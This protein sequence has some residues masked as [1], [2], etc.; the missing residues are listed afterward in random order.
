MKK[1]F[2]LAILLFSLMPCF[3]EK[4]TL[5]VGSDA[6]ITDTV[7]TV[8]TL[9]DAS[10]E[11][12]AIPLQFCVKVDYYFFSLM[13][14]T[15]LIY[16]QPERY[17]PELEVLFSLQ[18]EIYFVN[19]KN[20]SKFGIAGFVEVGDSIKFFRDQ[21]FL[22][23]IMFGPYFTNTMSVTDRIQVKND[24]GA[25]IYARG[26]GLTILPLLRSGIL[27]KIGD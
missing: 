5:Y 14:G 22:P 26:T 8:I 11:A 3:A 20:K 2:C 10:P 9:T 7:L 4:A 13:A 25:L 1:S 6:M 23:V 21:Y 19:I 27:F 24:L 17:P 12:F 16:T 15:R 18:P